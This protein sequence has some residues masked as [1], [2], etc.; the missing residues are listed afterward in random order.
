MT[1]VHYSSARQDWATPAEVFTYLSAR[2]GPFT[3]DA[4]ADASNSKCP[5][6]Y[7]EGEDALTRPWV[8]RV[9]CNPPYS[10]VAA[11]VEHAIRE[12][13]A[14]RAE[15][16]VLLVP[17]RPDTVWFREAAEHASEI[18]M[19][20]GRITF[21]GAPA[22]APFPSCAIVLRAPA[23]WSA[24]ERITYTMPK[25]HGSRPRWYTLPGNAS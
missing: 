1:S 5:T 23:T 19:R 2:Y 10:N 6:F 9:W 20:S 21:E 18:L 7:G 11:F 14:G 8:G 15:V 17:A 13:Q 22:P 12:T 4:A 25:Q 3:L 24:S 16:V